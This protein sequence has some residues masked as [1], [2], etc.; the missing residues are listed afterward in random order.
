MLMMLKIAGIL[1]GLYFLICILLYFYQESMIFFPDRLSPAHQFTFKQPFEEINIPTSDGTK[2]HGVL[3][4][5]DSSKGLIFYLHGNAGSIDTWGD[6]AKIYADFNYDVFMLDYRGY[7]KSEGSINS[8]QQLLDDVQAAYNTMK[9]SYSEDSIVVLGYSVG[10]GP[11]TKIASTNNPKMLILQA[12][13]YSILDMM[14]YR[15]KI[16]PS[17]ILKYPMETNKFIEQCKMPVIVFHGE[18]DDIIYY[19]SSVK[20]KELFKS[21]DTLVTLKNQGHHDI[22]YNPDYLRAMEKLIG[23]K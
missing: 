19:G 23:T 13:Y 21:T 17:F 8:Q 20:L 22:S 16:L 5:A 10:S 11:A 15:Y 12:P 4:K 7:G 14:N 18:Q 9:K 3:F 1:I 2:L 6:A